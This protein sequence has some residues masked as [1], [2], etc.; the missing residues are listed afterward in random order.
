VSGKR[1][2]EDQIVV[3]LT[4]DPGSWKFCQPIQHYLAQIKQAQWSV[5]SARRADKLL[6]EM[7]FE[8]AY[9]LRVR[10][11]ARNYAGADLDMHFSLVRDL[12]PLDEFLRILREHG[13]PGL[14]SRLERGTL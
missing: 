9:A 11:F 3:C 10:A 5:L 4:T 6:R 2:I 1:Q 13:M 7:L 8:R 14:A 12:Q